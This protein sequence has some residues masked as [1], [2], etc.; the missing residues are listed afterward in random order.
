MKKHLLISLISLMP[1]FALQA[2][3][4]SAADAVKNMGLGWNL[5]NT[6][7]ASNS[8]GAMPEDASYWNIQGIESENCWGQ[9]TTSKEL[10]KMMK[11]AGFGAIRVPITWYNHMDADGKV[12]AAWMKR[13]HEVVD[14]IINEDL[15]CI[16]N[17]HHDTG[18]D[19]ASYHSWIKA[20][21]D[22]YN[23]Y[24]D[25]FEGLWTQIAEDF[26]DY[27]Q[28]LVFAG[29]NEMLDAVKYDNVKVGS[30]CY[31]SFASAGQYDEAV[32]KSAYEAI[33]GYAQSFVNAVRAT[34]GNNADRNLVVP[35]YA[36]AG[37]VGAGTGWNN[38]HLLEPLTEMK[39]PEDSAEGH[40]IFEVHSYPS[41]K[42][43]DPKDAWKEKLNTMT[44]DELI[45][46]VTAHLKSK[47]APVIVGEWGTS[48]VDA[49]VTD[50]DADRENYLKFVEYY[51]QKMKEND[52]ATFY[53]MGLTDGFYRGVPAFH[54]PE[55]AEC[56]AKAYHGSDF[57]G[58]YPEVTGG[59]E[60]VCFEGEKTMQWGQ[61]IGIKGDL[62][63]DF[64][65]TVQLNVT[66]TQQ[67]L[68]PVDDDDTYR[69]LQFWYGDWSE[70]INIT[71]D[72]KVYEHDFQPWEH[73]GTPQGTEH[74]TGFTFDEDTYNTILKRGFL[75]Q[76]YGIIVTKVTLTDY[77]PSSLDGISND[78]PSSD[79]I[80]D[81]SGRQVV[82]PGTGIFIQGGK[83]MIRNK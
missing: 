39:Y 43:K 14:Y 12:D 32:A 8:N 37:G 49:S 80:F 67:V 26:K 5:G 63:K 16:I 18:C 61:S 1:A 81:L 24:K 53:W 74:T 65:P 10:I 82:N 33:N 27:G 22:N 72:G 42:A 76:G 52:I 51:V 66:Y 70:Q 4:E 56:M 7:D 60:V 59:D 62:F 29:Y 78:Q 46:D 50:Y 21:L 41:L 34:G 9:P 2:Q 64:G 38:D 19:G 58:E 55:I 54:Q 47:G 69:G 20:D 79:V 73:Y 25:K 71:V 57:K 48:N 45:E 30:W 28:K 6:L 31:A 15:Y 36:A 3:T 44:V 17:V 40:I 35:T 68:P 23:T 75:F 83:K 13:V 11:N 77:T